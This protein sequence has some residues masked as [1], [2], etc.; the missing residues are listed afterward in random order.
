[1]PRTNFPYTFDR[2]LGVSLRVGLSR[3][4]FPGAGRST[5]SIHYLLR[6]QKGYLRISLT[7]F[8]SLQQ[9][10]CPAI[11][12]AQPVRSACAPGNAPSRLVFWPVTFLQIRAT[13]KKTSCFCP[14]AAGEE[15]DLRA[16]AIGIDA[17]SITIA[18]RR[19]S[20]SLV[21]PF[22]SL[23][24]PFISLV[25]PFI[26]LVYP[27]ISLVYPFIS[28][29]YPFISLVYPFISLVYPFISIVYPFISLFLCAIP[30]FLCPI[31]SFL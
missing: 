13:G 9:T 8:A 19:I 4:I 30:S 25:Y 16:F 18:R 21:Y 11:A 29:V 7:R 22:I 24:Y 6:A 2:Y 3:S 5:F 31:P 23:V 26:S 14:F 27:F 17:M 15:A 10:V 12:A 1:M 20:F 28:L